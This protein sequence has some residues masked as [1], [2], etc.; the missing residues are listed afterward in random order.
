MCPSEVPGGFQQVEA[1]R[2]TSPSSQCGRCE[3]PQ[4]GRPVWGPDSHLS[5]SA[6]V[7]DVSA[8]GSASAV[9]PAAG[10][11]LLAGVRS[12]E[13]GLG[14]VTILCRSN[15]RLA[16]LAKVPGTFHLQA[17]LSNLWVGQ[18]TQIPQG[19]AGRACP[20]QTQ[21]PLVDWPLPPEDGRRAWTLTSCSSV[22]ALPLS[23]S[24]SLPRAWACRSLA[25][26]SRH[27]G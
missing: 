5:T 19:K 1:S 11:P 20:P 21:Q 23:S 24:S 18:T 9:P 8:P 3:P 26:R 10:N 2:S 22:L 25:S 16:H 27:K 6:P 4:S 15:S 13:R 17:R 14:R 7:P 12:A